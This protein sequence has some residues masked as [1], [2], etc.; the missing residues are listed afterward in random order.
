MSE[1]GGHDPPERT[2][3]FLCGDMYGRR[4]SFGSIIM[5]PLYESEGMEE[6][7]DGVQHMFPARLT[8]TP[9]GRLYP[10]RTI[11][12]FEP[13]PTSTRLFSCQKVIC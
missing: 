3:V 12:A 11:I 4:T 7:H 10:G 8:S 2:T 9:A 6:V 1:Q 5:Q 13:L